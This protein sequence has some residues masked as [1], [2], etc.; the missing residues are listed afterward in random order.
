MT[1]Q[2]LL[3]QLR[4]LMDKLTADK[5]TLSPNPKVDKRLEQELIQLR[6]KIKDR[7][8]KGAVKHTQAALA[9]ISGLFLWNGSLDSSHV[10]S[11]DLENTTGSYLHGILHRIEPDYSNAKYWFRMAGSHPDGKQ[12]QQNMLKLLRESVYINELPYQRLA[13]EKLWNPSLF[14]DIVAAFLQK[15]GPEEEGSLLE[16]IQ[17]EELRLLLEAEFQQLG[18]AGS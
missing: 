6:E 9:I 11:Q 5:V 4:E 2:E 13:Q 17:A 3:N 14:T 16:R 15:G 1:N 8:G 18:Q 7:A 12:L 10:I